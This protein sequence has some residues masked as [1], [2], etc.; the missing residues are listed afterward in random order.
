MKKIFNEFWI[1]L[2]FWKWNWVWFSYEIEE[3]KNEIRWLWWKKI[4]INKIKDIYFRFQILK[5]VLIL[6][7][8]DWI[9]FKNKDK[10]WL[11]IIIWF[12][13]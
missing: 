13:D 12:S 7:K 10:Y 9:K 2:V 3:W 8:I 5:K 1:S 4:K 6:S 11:K